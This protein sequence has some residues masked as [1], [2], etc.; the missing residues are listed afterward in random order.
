M[1]H[2]IGHGITDWHGGEMEYQGESGAINEAYS[3]ILGI[4]LAPSTD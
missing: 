2:E 3:D 4:N 1:C